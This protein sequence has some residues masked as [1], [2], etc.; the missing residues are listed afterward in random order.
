[1]PAERVLTADRG[2]DGV[3]LDL[4]VRR[5]LA[6]LSAAS[7]TRVQAWI[8]S[9]CVRVNGA[10][11]RRPSTRTAAG[12]V[13]S[14]ALPDAAPRRQPAAEDVALDVLYED[15][16]LLAI[17]KPAGMVAHPSYRNTTGTLLN[18]LLARARTWPRGHRP[19]LVSRLDKSTSGVIV[20]AKTASMH[21]ALQRAMTENDAEK[22]YVA[23]VYGL[24]PVRGVIDLPLAHDERDRRRRIVALTAAGAPSVTRFERLARVKPPDA[25]LSLL[26]C[27][28]VTGR[29]HQIRVHLSAR[30]FPIVGDP[31]YGE[32]RWTGIVDAALRDTL[33]AFPRQALHASRVAFAHPV[34]SER[35][36]VDAPVAEDF[37]ALIDACGFDRVRFK[38]QTSDFR[39]QTSDFEL[40]KSD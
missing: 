28:L 18:A 8:E 36:E 5:H 30:G 4:V 40:P 14:V 38:L 17:N 7:R 24:P 10:A 29:R 9:G 15:D 12:D 11:V 33:R 21:A 26:R 23:L 27:R 1:V 39:L 13:V 32:P 37:A 2:D 31:A 20:V 34:T 25:V 3:R 22:Q 6:D 35:V 16:H 19:S